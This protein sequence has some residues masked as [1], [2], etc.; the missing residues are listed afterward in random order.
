MAV[1]YNAPLYQ[2]EP[3][4][5]DEKKCAKAAKHWARDGMGTKYPWPGYIGCTTSGQYG[6]HRYNGGTTINGEWWQGEVKPLPIVHEKYE[7]I[8]VPTWGYRI[9][10]KGSGPK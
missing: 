10:L 5:W 6:T 7:I 3:E 1:D 4:V 8:E 2:H 9:V